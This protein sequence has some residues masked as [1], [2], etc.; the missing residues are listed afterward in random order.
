VVARGQGSSMIHGHPDN[1]LDGVSIENLKLFV[2]ND[3]ASPLQK[4]VDAIQVRWAR[5]LK[6]KDVEVIWDKP[7]SDKWQSAL[8]LDDAQDVELEGFRGRQAGAASPAVQF[9]NV[10]GAVV[11]NSKALPGTAAFLEI[12][13]PASRAIKLSGNDLGEAKTP[14]RLDPGVRRDAVRPAAP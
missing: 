14:Y 3:P 8:R 11:R 5:N 7:A 2:S 12:A 10:Q 6:L 9:K 1:W 4:T 13:G